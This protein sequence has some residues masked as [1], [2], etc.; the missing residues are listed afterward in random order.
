MHVLAESALEQIH[1]LL[2]QAKFVLKGL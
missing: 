2:L 1:F